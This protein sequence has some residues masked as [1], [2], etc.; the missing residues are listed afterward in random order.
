MNDFIVKP[1]EA[2]TLYSNLAKWLSAGN[3]SKAA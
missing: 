1:V 3:A 2:D